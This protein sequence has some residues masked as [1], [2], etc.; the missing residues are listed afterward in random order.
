VPAGFRHLITP[1]M[2]QPENASFVRLQLLQRRATDARNDPSDKPALE[3][4]LD[5][6]D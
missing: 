2:Q 5:H 6:R 4:H 1:A 3:A